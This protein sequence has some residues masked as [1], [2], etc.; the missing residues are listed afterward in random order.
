LNISFEYPPILILP[1]IIIAATISLFLYR[2]DKAFVDLEKWKIYLMS[3]LRFF[4]VLIILLL[5]LN[6]IIKTISISEHKPVIVFAQ[7][8]SSSMLLNKDSVFYQTEYKQKVNNLINVLSEDY[9]VR[10]LIFSEFSVHDSIIDFQGELT[11]ISSVFAE[12][13]A[14]YS[15]MN[16]GGV[17][18]ATDGI[19]NHGMNPVYS[20]NLRYPV[21]AV[22]LGD[23]VQQKDIILRELMHNKIAFL[24]NRFPLRIY[25]TAEKCEE[26][27]TFLRIIRDDK[28]VLSR[29]IRIPDSGETKI[30]NVELFADKIGLQQYKV[31]IDPIEGEISIDN[32]R[33]DFVIDVIDNRQKILILANAPHPDI[34]ALNYAIKENPN[35][36]TDIDFINSFS[37]NAN[38]YDLIIL[39]QLP[40]KTNNASAVLSV[41]EKNNIP[42]LY[43]L[44][45]SSSLQGFNNLSAG[46]R[47]YSQTNSMENAR[48]SVSNNFLLFEAGDNI[49]TLMASVPPLRVF[50]GEYAATDDLRVLMYQEINNVR[51]DK[52][53]IAFV[54]RYEYK[55]GFI[56]GEG[57]WKWRLTDFRHFSTHDNF[58]ELINKI[59]Q[60]LSVKRITER[61]ISDYKRIYNENE[62]V[63]INAELYNE[64]YEL[65][66]SQ[67]VELVLTDEEGMEYKYFFSH[68]GNAYRL[69][70][71]KL[72]PGKYS[73]IASVDYDGKK[74]NTQGDFIVQEINL[75]SLA[76]TA[77]H[78]LL[79]RIAKYTGGE[80][81]YPNNMNEIPEKLRQN[82]NI[83][84]IAT[85]QEKNL[86]INDLW[87]LFFVILAFA[88]TEWFLRKFW[89]SY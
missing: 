72:S 28:E 82:P 11:D 4:F 64:A 48:P 6:P 34:G 13:V 65:V 19:Y 23:T 86:N 89:G 25:I 61:L 69:D 17:I 24:G 37:G 87:P 32:N 18:L 79:Y 85:K 73:F 8:N 9:D 88:G 27:E 77:D 7:D 1:A 59:V 30:I 55:N 42:V 62:S 54:D 67:S 49:R 45:S 75:E 78:A 21:Y 22:A 81:F 29:K 63:I 14:R 15:G 44:G 35:F 76:T 36:E 3:A 40:S 41:I 5:L 26:K 39:H 2:K 58:K 80:V 12:I 10:Q 71:G 74:Y 83:A 60:Y 84:T 33:A 47:V 46:I 51:T 16:L 20:R 56:L 31:F 66:P 52:P 68:Y 38:E 70:A 43:I 53:L 50:F 57:L